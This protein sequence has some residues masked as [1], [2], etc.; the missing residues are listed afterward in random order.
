MAVRDYITEDIEVTEA[1]VV[2]GRDGDRWQIKGQIKSLSQ[3]PSGPFFMDYK[4]EVIRKGDHRRVQLARGNLKQ[5]KTGD[6]DWD[7]FWELV[8]WDTDEAPQ[9]ISQGKVVET[10]DLDRR[11][12][13]NSAVNNAVHLHGASP[14]D[15]V[16]WGVIR[17][18][19]NIL[20]DIIT[21]GPP[22]NHAPEASDEMDGDEPETADQIPGR[23]CAIPEHN[24]ALLAKVPNSDRL[25]H[26]YRVDGTTHWCYGAS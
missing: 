16:Q 24:S 19:A 7:Y 9:S 18:W 8:E 25:G 12:A 1:S 6:K 3:Y 5:G 2:Q 4:G 11:I 26:P 20:Y 22:Q 21:A 14:P 17:E 15:G 10:P 13:W 23:H